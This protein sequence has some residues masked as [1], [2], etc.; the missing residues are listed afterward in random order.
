MPFHLFAHAMPSDPDQWIPHTRFPCEARQV[1]KQDVVVQGHSTQPSGNVKVGR[2]SPSDLGVAVDEIEIDRED[3]S[4]RTIAAH[5]R[6][7]AIALDSP[8]VVG[9]THAAEKR[10][11]ESAIDDVARSAS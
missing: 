8:R 3:R 10:P 11:V 4:L 5:T 7:D 1:T 2:H 9:G 6:P